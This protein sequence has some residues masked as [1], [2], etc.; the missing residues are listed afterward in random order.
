MEY[1]FCPPTQLHPTLETKLV[2]NL[3]FAGQIN[4]TSGYEE[5]AAQGLMAGTNA[6]LKTLGKPSLVLRR[7]QAYIGVMIDDLVTKGTDEP[8]R[9]FTSRAEFRLLLRQDNADLRLAPLAFETGLITRETFRKTED[10]QNASEEG[11]AKA[12]LLKHEGVSLSTWLKRP[13]NDW[14]LLP[15]ELKKMFHVATLGIRSTDIQYEGHIERQKKQAEKITRMESK[16]IPA[17]I[18]YERVHALKKEA[19]IKLGSI[20]PATIGQASRIPGITPADIA[21]LLVHLQKRGRQQA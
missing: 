5:A 11:I 15:E 17:D 14:T 6:A 8:Y 21:L 1:D 10:R 16:I 18:D 19:V 3:Y 20:R 2:E 12:A 9:M 4:G 7:D 13:G